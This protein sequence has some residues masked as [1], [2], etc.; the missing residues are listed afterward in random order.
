MFLLLFSSQA[1]ELAEHT[2]KISLLEDAKRRK[3]EEAN[4]WQLRVRALPE[5]TLRLMQ[6]L[7]SFTAG[8]YIMLDTIQLV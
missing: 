2:A 6:T 3:E 1:A 7:L 8:N 4:S 5:S